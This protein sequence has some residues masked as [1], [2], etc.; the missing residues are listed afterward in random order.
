MKKSILSVVV[1]FVGFIS[2]YIGLCY[3]V[4]G[5]RIKLES[6]MITYFIKSINHMALFKSMV[7][8]IIG[9]VFA[10]ISFLIVKK[11]EVD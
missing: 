8:F 1:F 3:L 4:P 5:L 11:C 7:S 6:D 9:L 10:S 2:T